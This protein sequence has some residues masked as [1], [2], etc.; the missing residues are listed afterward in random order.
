MFGIHSPICNQHFGAQINKA[1]QIRT[2][3]LYGNNVKTEAGAPGGSFMH[4]HQVM[5]NV[6]LNDLRNAHIMLKTGTDAFS[7]AVSGCMEYKKRLT[8][9]IVPDMIIRAHGGATSNIMLDFNFL[10]STS[11]SYK[12]A[13]GKFGGGAELR[14]KQAR[15]NYR[16]AVQYLDVM[17]NGNIPETTGPAE[18]ILN[19]YRDRGSGCTGLI[20]GEHGNLSSA[21]LYIRDLITE[22]LASRQRES[23]GIFRQRSFTFATSSLYPSRV[24]IATIT[25]SL[26]TTH[27]GCSNVR[28]TAV[29]GL[30]ATRAWAHFLIERIQ[31]LVFGFDDVTQLGAQA[32]QRQFY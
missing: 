31:I 14:Q 4:V 15:R 17:E 19:R 24:G 28:S 20:I 22:S 9:N 23:T 29:G 30:T 7:G 11:N 13:E 27:R 25:A 5:V 26:L 32:R 21:Y 6:V 2:V 18:E 8:H 12:H 1:N 3:D 10:F 16:T